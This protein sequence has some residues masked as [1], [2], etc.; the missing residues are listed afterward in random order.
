MKQRKPTDPLTMASRGR[1][2]VREYEELSAAFDAVRDGFLEALANTKLGEHD[3]RERL[4]LSVQS[5]DAIKQALLS[6]ASN[7][8]LQEH[9]EAMKKVMNG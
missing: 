1:K 6:V 2:A 5:L 7:A 4:Y 3:A 9:E 8:S